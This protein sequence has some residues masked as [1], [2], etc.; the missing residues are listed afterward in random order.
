MLAMNLCIIKINQPFRKKS[1]FVL[2]Q[3]RAPALAMVFTFYIVII[4]LYFDIS[5]NRKG[6]RLY[7]RGEIKKKP[8]GFVNIK[9]YFLM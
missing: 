1:R 3:R 4:S 7:T 5:K 9:A 6:F 8:N 2:V